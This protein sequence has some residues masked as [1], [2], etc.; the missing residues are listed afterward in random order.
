MSAKRK[1]DFPMSQ[2][3]SLAAQ[4]AGFEAHANVEADGLSITVNTDQGPIHARGIDAAIRAARDYIGQFLGPRAT[5]IS[6]GESSSP[7]PRGLRRTVS[8]HS[9]AAA[10]R[11]PSRNQ[12]LYGSAGAGT[13]TA[14]CR[15]S[16]TRSRSSTPTIAVRPAADTPHSH[17]AGLGLGL[18]LGRR[19]PPVGPNL[20]V[21]TGIRR[22]LSGWRGPWTPPKTAQNASKH[23]PFR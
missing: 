8:G 18:G 7:S 19:T 13:T 22:Y 11:R 15:R 12:R 16:R 5:A 3:F 21:S 2:L 6:R 1:G 4:K 9:Q 14:P 17:P 20:P 10:A 23:G